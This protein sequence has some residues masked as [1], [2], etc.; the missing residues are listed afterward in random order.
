MSR[1]RRLVNSTDD[2]PEKKKLKPDFSQ[3]GTLNVAQNTVKGIVLKYAEPPEARKSEEKHRLY[4]F[5]KDQEIGNTCPLL[6]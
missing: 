3:S 6:I 1:E 2:G 5:K 4:V